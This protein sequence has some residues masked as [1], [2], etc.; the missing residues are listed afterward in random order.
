MAPRNSKHGPAIQVLT[1]AFAFY[2]AAG[3]AML[4]GVGI[5]I[6]INQNL[7]WNIRHRAFVASRERL[8][9]TKEMEPARAGGSTLQMERGP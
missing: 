1:E 6:T 3:E 8:D 5:S 9:L 7:G 2:D 4:S